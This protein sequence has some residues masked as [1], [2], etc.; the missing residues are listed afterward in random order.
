MIERI[1]GIAALF[2]G[3]YLW[4]TDFYFDLLV[5]ILF[6]IAL[7]DLLGYWVRKFFWMRKCA[8]GRSLNSTV[9]FE[10]SESGISSTSKFST[11]HLS[12]DGVEKVRRTDK[13]L[14]V[15]PQKGVYMYFP[16]AMV[17]SEPIDFICDMVT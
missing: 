10:L 4:V 2:G 12:W 5:W 15:W 17:G 1:I 7:V 6:A 13:G 16:E 11:G 9:E 8:D 3:I 14:I